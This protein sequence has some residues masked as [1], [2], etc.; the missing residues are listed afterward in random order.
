M[1]DI[2]STSNKTIEYS[3]R[4]TK[5]L[6]LAPDPV[7]AAFRDTIILFATDPH[8]ASLRNHPLRGKL[9]GYQ[10]IDITEDWRAVF[11]VK[12]IG[13]RTVIR[14]SQIGT[15]SWHPQAAIYVV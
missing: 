5:Q 6:I 7:K 13:E 9:A 8:H 3:E 2:K 4:F 14:F 12:Q 10:S 15:H 11:R 1:K